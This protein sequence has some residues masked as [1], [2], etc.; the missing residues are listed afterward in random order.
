MKYKTCLMCAILLLIA[1]SV[2]AL[3]FQTEIVQERL[4]RD[5][6]TQWEAEVKFKAAKKMVAM[7]CLAYYRPNEAAWNAYIAQ[8]FGDRYIPLQ[9]WDT[10]V[11]HQLPFLESEFDPGG[12][13]IIHYVKK[14]M[15]NKIVSLGG[16]RSVAKHYSDNLQKLSE[17][18][19]MFEILNTLWE[20]YENLSGE[21]PKISIKFDI[22]RM[23][24]AIR[25]LSRQIALAR[26]S[27]SQSSD[28]DVRIIRE[29]GSNLV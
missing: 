8:E 25:D 9:I 29:T 24:V 16:L 26:S 14:T 1:S 19:R 4:L 6:R 28:D 21:K 3:T 13:Q 7:R 22:Q 18:I 2:H 23:S 12:D 11:H 10:W 17:D 15:I 20:T 27:E 5:W